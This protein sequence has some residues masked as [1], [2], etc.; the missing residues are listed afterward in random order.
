MWLWGKIDICRALGRAGVYIQLTHYRW[1]SKVYSF[2]YNFCISYSSVAVKKRKLTKATYRS[3][4]LFG[5]LFQRD[6]S[7][8]WWG[9]MGAS[10]HGGRRK[11]RDHIS[12]P[13]PPTQGRGSKLK[14]PQGYEFSK[15][16]LP[17]PRIHFLLQGCTSQAS[18]NRATNWGPSIQTFEPMGDSSHLN[19]HT[20]WYN[21]IHC[22]LF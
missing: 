5:L 1:G 3:K 10:R 19:H 4:D 11:L 20:L 7:P 12:M 17:S 14:V 2:S 18:P 8:S 15:L 22:Q 21:V 16:P 6:K 9:G 13:P